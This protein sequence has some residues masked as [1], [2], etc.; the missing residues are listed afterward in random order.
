MFGMGGDAAGAFSGAGPRGPRPGYAAG[1]A[2][3]DFSQFSGISN[4]V[5]SDNELLGNFPFFVRVS[6][7]IPRFPSSNGS[8][9]TFPEDI[10]R[11]SHAGFRTRVRRISIGLRSN[12][13]GASFMIC[14]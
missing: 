2:R 11:V 1:G 9:R 10:R 4:H 13:R 6:T 14:T 8:R 3:P 7:R 12:S 5:F